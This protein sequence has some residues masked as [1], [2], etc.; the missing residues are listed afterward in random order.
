MRPENFSYTSRCLITSSPYDVRVGPILAIPAILSEHGVRPRLAFSKAGVDPELF[1]DADARV[2]LDAVGRLLDICVT[3]TKTN[4][5]GLLV[6]ERFNLDALG[7]VG[8][9]M[10]NSATIGDALRNLLL[11]LHL[12]DRGAAPIL[13]S[14]APDYSILG[15]SVYRH[16]TPALAQIYDA[17]IAIAYRIMVGLCGASWK[18]KRVQFSYGP[19][20]NAAPHMKLFGAQVSFDAEVSGVVFASHWLKKS[21]EGAD[22]VLRGVLIKAI[23]EAEANSSMSFTEQVKAVLPQM[24]LSG[25]ISANAIASLF[26][27]SERTL[28]RRLQENSTSLHQLLHEARFEMAQQLLGNTRLMVSEVAGALRYDDPNVFSRAFH[29]WAGL[30]PT[31]WRDQQ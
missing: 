31:Q 9:L 26:G 20:R 23:Q 4:H 13:I 10:R 19:P 1:E 25:S 8:D 22:P 2:A 15:Y 21:I 17:A 6:G 16:D 11:H 28:R 14:P 30:S 7:P 29:N 24:V 27:I 12:Y 18:P 5:F 3:L